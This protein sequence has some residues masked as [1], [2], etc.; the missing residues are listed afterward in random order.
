MTAKQKLF[1][2]AVL[3]HPLQTKADEEAGNRPKSKMLVEVTVVLADSDG[4]V[5]TLAARAIPEAY[6][7]KLDQ[8][9]ILVR[10]F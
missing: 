2:Y 1:Q 7:D 6:L 10:P 8:V 5:A 9:E 4:Q 3:Y